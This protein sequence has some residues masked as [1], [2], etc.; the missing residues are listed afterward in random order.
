MDLGGLYKYNTGAQSEGT[1]PHVTIPLLGRFK[2]ETGERYH[3]TPMAAITRSGI[4]L[5][6]W[7]DLLLRMHAARG[8][9]K[10]PAFCDQK[11]LRMKSSM[12]QRVILDL[13]IKIQ[14]S[15]PLIIPASVDV[16]EEYG[17]SRS[18]R[19][20]ATTHARNCGVKLSDIKAANRWRDKE[21]AQ[22]RSINQ[23]MADHYS[24]V[25]QLLPTLLRFSKAL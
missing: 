16:L 1:E 10:G 21:N 11:G 8:R 25:K 24:E 12:M 19:R 9:K 3:L 6:F 7:I 20:G 14:I 18:F 15:D 13:L 22:G 5:K 2:G 4:K 17:I 23:P